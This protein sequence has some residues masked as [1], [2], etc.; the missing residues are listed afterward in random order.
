MGR[1]HR[2]ATGGLIQVKWR[3]IKI[4]AAPLDF[5][6]YDAIIQ[7]MPIYE[8]HCNGCGKEFEALVRS[9]TRVECPAC[10]S[11]ALEKKLSVFA[12]SVSGGGEPAMAAGPCGSCGHPDGPGSCG[13]N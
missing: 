11:T 3:R 1:S 7:H 4:S 12:T 5:F 2:C 10:Q 8:Y 13:L 9:S 6:G